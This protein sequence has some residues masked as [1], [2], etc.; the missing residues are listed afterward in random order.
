MKL[1]QFTSI[2]Y[3][4][5]IFQDIQLT[6]KKYYHTNDIYKLIDNFQIQNSNFVKVSTIGYT[7]QGTPL[8]IIQI[9]PDNL[10]NKIIWID[11]GKFSLFEIV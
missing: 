9:N 2:G 10:K 4:Y 3:L 1:K 7:I 11:G 8:K 5:F 6:S